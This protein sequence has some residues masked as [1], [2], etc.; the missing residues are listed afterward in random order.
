MRS[1]AFYVL[2]LVIYDLQAYLEI[3]EQLAC[4]DRVHVPCVSVRLII[5][6]ESQI[7]LL[8]PT[9]DDHLLVCNSQPLRK[10]EQKLKK[11]ADEQRK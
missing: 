7:K 8:N 1:H 2:L 10:Q 5:R 9:C 6:V 11:T 3:V 4:A